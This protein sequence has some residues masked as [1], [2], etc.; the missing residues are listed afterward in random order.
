MSARNYTDCPWC[1]QCAKS[2]QAE[3]SKVAADS[4]GRVSADE[5]GKL[6]H[7]ANSVKTPKGTLGEYYEMWFDEKGTF[8][9]RYESFCRE[10][11][12]EF[13]TV[14]QVP[15]AVKDQT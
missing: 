10:C 14:H 1:Q 5:Y 2:A 13:N 6:V 3:R 7:A 11:G 12:F 8:H 15:N 9:F 4:Y